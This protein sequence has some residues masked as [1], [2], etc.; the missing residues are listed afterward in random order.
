MNNTLTDTLETLFTPPTDD[1][2]EEPILEAVIYGSRV[3][4]NDYIWRSF[5]GR[6]YK[7]GVEYHGPVYTLG[8]NKVAT[9]ARLCGC[10]I[11]QADVAPRNR[12][13]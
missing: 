3:L 10:A 11:C 6:R 13:N 2:S 9:C 1:I 4:T 5:T 7:N 8:N 12:K